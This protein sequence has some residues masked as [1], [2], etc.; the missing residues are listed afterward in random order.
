MKEKKLMRKRRRMFGLEQSALERV[1]E[2]EGEEEG[3]G[4]GEAEEEQIESIYIICAYTCG[5]IH[6]LQCTCTCVNKL[7]NHITSIHKHHTSLHINTV[8]A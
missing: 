7:Y 1:G 3:E 5:A 8:C 6:V 4:E 2:E